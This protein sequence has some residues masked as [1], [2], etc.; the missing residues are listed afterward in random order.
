MVASDSE[1]LDLRTPSLVRKP[2]FSSDPYL[3]LKIGR[4]LQQEKERNN[5][6]TSITNQQYSQRW[7]P[8]C[9]P[10]K[11]RWSA[12]PPTPKS[13]S[14]TP[15]STSRTRPPSAKST[16]SSAPSTTS[17]SPSSPPRASRPPPSRAATS[18]S[19][20]VTGC[21]HWRCSCPSRSLRRARRR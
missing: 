19:S 4:P 1:T 5:L 13:P 18:S 6:G 21:C 15:Q 2:L 9:T 20:E 8:S 16:R 12:P 7:A 11:A 10:V 3:H 14:S 17:T